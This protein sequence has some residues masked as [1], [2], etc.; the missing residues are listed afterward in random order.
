MGLSMFVETLGIECQS[1]AILIGSMMINDGLGTKP[2]DL[3][4][5]WA[6]VR[7]FQTD[8]CTLDV[9]LWLW[10]SRLGL[11]GL[12]E[13]L[14]SGCGATKDWTNRLGTSS[15]CKTWGGPGLEKWEIAWTARWMGGMFFFGNTLE[16][17]IAMP[18]LPGFLPYEIFI[19]NHHKSS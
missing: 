7:R 8:Q 17:A 9:C 4:L 12:V 10:N 1:I 3:E 15:F 2:P 13:R 11:P 5:S 18:F 14:P 19:I 6:R 16:I